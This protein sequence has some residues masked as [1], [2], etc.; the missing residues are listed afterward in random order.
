MLRI[1]MG[2][3]RKKQPPV[4]ELNPSQM[5]SWEGPTALRRTLVCGDAYVIVTVV[6]LLH[7]GGHCVKEIKFR[8][9]FI[10]F[11]GIICPVS[12]CNPLTSY[13]QGEAWRGD[14]RGVFRSH[15]YR[16]RFSGKPVDWWT[17]G[18]LIYEMIVGYPP[19]VDEERKPSEAIGSHRKPWCLCEWKK[20][21]VQRG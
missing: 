2:V 7:I 20:Y 4:I 10:H 12:M 16:T 1:D 21:W 13:L 15:A 14:Q 17:L 8:H 11:F 6:Y 9:C 18:I 19:F 5:P 3:P